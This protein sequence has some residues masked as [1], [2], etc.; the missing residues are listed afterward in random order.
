MESGALHQ[1]YLRGAMPA[2]AAS[3]NPDQSF[4]KALESL[5]SKQYQ[6]CI[7]LIHSAMDQ[8]KQEG[9]S[10]NPKMKYLSYMGLALTLSQGRSEEGIKLCE[11]AVKR[12]FYDPDL[13]CN[14]GIVYLRNRRRKEAFDMFRKG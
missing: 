5:E 8:E 9:G 14:L 7:A 3:S 1:T 12:E 4:L 13:F 10:Q 11:Q 2:E 6:Q